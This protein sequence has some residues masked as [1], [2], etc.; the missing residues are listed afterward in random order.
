[1]HPLDSFLCKDKFQRVQHVADVVLGNDERRLKCHDVA[2]DA[3]LAD[4]KAALL[5]LLKHEVEFG[6]GG[7]FVRV[8]ELRADHQAESAYVADD[9]MAFLDFPKSCAQ[10]RSAPFGVPHEIV[11]LDVADDLKPCRCG[12]GVAAEG[13]CAGFRVGIRDFGGRNEC[14]DGRAVAERFRHGHDIGCNAKMLDGEHLARAREARLHLV[15]NEENT[16]VVKDLLDALEVVLRWDDDARIALNRLGDEG[17]GATGGRTL[18]RLLKLVGAV[19]AA[20]LG[21]MLM[22]TA[23]AVGVLDKVNAADGIRVGAPHGDAREAHRELCAS[24]Q[25][26][27]QSDEL[28]AARGNLGEERRALVRLRARGAEETLLK[29]SR[30]DARKLLGEIDEVLREIDVADVLECVQLLRDGGI[31][32]GIAVSAV[33]DGDACE[34]V[35]IFSALTVVEILHL[36][37]HDLARVVVEMPETGHDVFLLLFKDDGGADVFVLVRGSYVHEA[38]FYF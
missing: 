36:A 7:G 33:D 20:L 30:C 34:A 37:A 15:R 22:R 29:V 17:G 32:R 18:D 9:G 6:G 21:C 27:A 25:S 31:D 13:R 23:V 38:S 5:Q 12:D 24:V 14:T 19:D 4:D 2:P 35:E 10:L 28:A 3:V 1:M 8:D 11:L 26:S 16:V